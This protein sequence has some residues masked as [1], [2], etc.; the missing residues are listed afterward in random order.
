MAGDEELV[1]NLLVNAIEFAGQARQSESGER[2]LSIVVST[3]DSQHLARTILNALR[4]Q[5][6][7]VIRTEV[8]P[9]PPTRKDNR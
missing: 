9:L 4:D 3:E 7:R 5:G 2:R 1:F 8:E 6:F